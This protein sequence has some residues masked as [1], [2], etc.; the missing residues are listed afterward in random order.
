MRASSRRPARLPASGRALAWLSLALAVAVATEA[1]VFAHRL[2]EYLQA[3][4][5]D[6]R[7]DGVSIELA[8]TPGAE[9]AASIAA[10][11]DRDRDGT[12]STD[13]QRTYA[14]DVAQA[15]RATLDDTPLQ[16]DLHGFSFPTTDQFRRGEGTIRLQRSARHPILS[17]GR[18]Q[19]SFNNGYLP[20]QSVYLANALV[21]V[22]PRISVTGQRRTFNQR[23]L[24]IDYAV[25]TV[26]AGVASG[27]LMLGVV[28][29]VLIAR[30][31]RRHKN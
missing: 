7:T 11:I 17:N 24:T 18:H 5:I 26:Q 23:E 13:E 19:L 3:A 6:L 27:G 31:T 2:D 30:H 29:A 14:R 21:P 20:G 16:L 22:S 10:T 15:L 9:I 28:A 8:L 12:T 4:R 1:L 25:G